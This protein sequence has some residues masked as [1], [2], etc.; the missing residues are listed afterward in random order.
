MGADKSAWEKFAIFRDTMG[1]FEAEYRGVY[2]HGLAMNSLKNNV[3]A[4]QTN[5]PEAAYM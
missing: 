4:K 2:D 1:K 5:L 3:F